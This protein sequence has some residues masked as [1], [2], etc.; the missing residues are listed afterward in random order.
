LV[1]SDCLGHVCG[2]MLYYMTLRCGL[3]FPDMVQCGPVQS[4]AV[5]HQ[6]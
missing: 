5:I 1:F 3:M 2:S 6:W 4:D